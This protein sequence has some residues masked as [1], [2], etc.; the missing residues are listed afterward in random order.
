MHTWG[1]YQL[2]RFKYLLYEPQVW[3]FA[4][5]TEVPTLVCLT[6]PSSLAQNDKKQVLLSFIVCLLSLFSHL[7]ETWI[8]NSALFLS[9]F[10][11]NQNVVM[12]WHNWKST[13]FLC[14]GIPSR[15]FT[16]KPLL[17]FFFKFSTVSSQKGFANTF[18]C[19]MGNTIMVKHPTTLLQYMLVKF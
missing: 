7:V 3:S 1:W 12:L 13:L 18:H 15:I 9:L 8:L 4:V 5:K 6:L 16:L 11:R 2:C 19:A 10:S 17:V 14:A